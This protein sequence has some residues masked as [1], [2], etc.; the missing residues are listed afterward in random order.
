MQQLN[1]KIVRLAVMMTIASLGCG[2]YDAYAAS[3]AKKPQVKANQ[4]LSMAELI[5]QSKAQDWRALDPE[6]TLVMELEKGQVVIELAPHFAPQSIANIKALVHENYFD[7]LAMIRS[8]DNYVA[9]WGDADEKRAIKNARDKLPAE[10]S[11]HADKADVFT[12]LPDADGYAPQV[13]HVNGFAVGRDPKTQQTWLTHCYGAVGVARGNEIDSGNGTSLY[14]IIGHAPRHLDRNVTVV[15]RVMQGIALLSS[16][17]RG[18][19]AMGFY[20]KAEERG[21]IKSVRLASDMPEA[22]RPRLEVVRTES[23]LFKDIVAAQRN[24]G[25][26]WYKHAANYIELCNVPIPV[27]AREP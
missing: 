15:G 25:G 18:T 27:R 3:E 22:E 10:F 5:K 24:R 1:H 4:A 19:G 9:Q 26:E 17:P 14:A 12:R 7:G 16:L 2:S 23:L 8:H 20:E 13:G 21:A 11:V 6:N